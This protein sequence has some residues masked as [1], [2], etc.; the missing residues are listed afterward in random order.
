MTCPRLS[1]V[2]YTQIHMALRHR[3][4]GKNM[5]ILGF[6]LAI[7]A[8]LANWML[9]RKMG[10]EGWESIVPL[11]NSYVMFET[12]YGNGWKFLTLL[13]PLYNIYVGIKLVIDLAHAFNQSTGF[14]IGMLFLPSIFLLILA[15]GDAQFRDGSGATKTEDFVSKATETVADAVGAFPKKKCPKCGKDI[16][17]NAEFCPFCGERYVEKVCPSCG[18]KMGANEAF[19]SKCG[20]KYEEQKSRVC[21]SCGNKLADDQVFCDVCGTKYE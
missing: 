8:L 2:Q 17:Q 15:F 14:G 10:R 11:Y 5:T 4:R 19:C 21:P 20:V 13:I 1:F 16:A 3:K 12:L 6:V 7:A 9:Y 18:A